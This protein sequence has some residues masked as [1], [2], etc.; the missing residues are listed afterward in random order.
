MIVSW[1]TILYGH[2]TLV[3]N[4]EWLDINHN[5]VQKVCIKN[6]TTA[7]VL[8]LKNGTTILGVRVYLTSLCTLHQKLS[9]VEVQEME[10]LT[11][12]FTEQKSDAITGY[13]LKIFNIL[14]SIVFIN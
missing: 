13:L 2:C 8:S 3:H 9:F 6:G 14:E 5:V 4:V 10:N 1:E 12:V 11:V 7:S